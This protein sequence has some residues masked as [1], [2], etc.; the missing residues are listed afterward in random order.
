MTNLRKHGQPPF[1]VAVVH[2]GPG[3]AGDMT[4]VARRL[5]SGRGVLEPLQTATS[6]EG[7][8]EELRTALEGEGDLPVALVGHSWGA[9][10]AYVVAARH[11]TLVAKLI[12]VSSGPFE[13][14][15][16]ACLEEA[17]RNRLSEDERAQWD[18]AVQALGDPAAEGKDAALAQLGALASRADSYDPIAREPDRPQ[19]VSGGGEL[20]QRVWH[21][22]AEMRRSGALLALAAQ[23]RCPVVA[24]HG[25]HDPHPAEGVREPLALALRDFRFI[26]LSKCG[27]TPWVERQARDR[28]YQVLSEELP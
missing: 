24:I 3:A 13:E 19:A 26:R 16:V 25:D 20:Y 18:A 17:R 8:I 6:L 9:W 11:P 15:Y 23:I 28:F 27:H 22:A 1:M 7:Q 14:R 10:L 2:G 5:A 12:L 4:P 21:K